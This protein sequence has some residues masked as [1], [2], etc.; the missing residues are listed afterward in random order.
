MHLALLDGYPPR[1]RPGGG[2]GYGPVRV[3]LIGPRDLDR[4]L[5]LLLFLGAELRRTLGAPRQLRAFVL[6]SL[7]LILVIG[8]RR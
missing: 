4:T 3:A 1:Q 7:L 5:V 6:I 8:C 2:G